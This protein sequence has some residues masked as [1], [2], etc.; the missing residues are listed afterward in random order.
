MR[1]ARLLLPA[2][3]LLA[4]MIPRHASAADSV[5]GLAWLAGDWY[6]KDG[7]LEMEERWTEPR[8][9]LMLYVH[10]DVKDGR[11]VSFEFGRVAAGPDGVITYFASPGGRPATPFKMI[12]SKGSRVVFENKQ[13]DFPKRILYWIAD[14]GSLHARIEGD[15]GDKEKAM[16]W[17]WKKGRF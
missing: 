16:E 6:G 9:G 3:A 10:R 1:N 8:G 12:E 15:P 7:P 5:A 13:N 11:A 14:D 2:L 17:T 4:T